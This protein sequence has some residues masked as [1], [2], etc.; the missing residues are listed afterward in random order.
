MVAAEVRNPVQ[1]SATAAR[2]IKGLIGSSVEKVG[3]GARL[4]ERLEALM[5]DIVVGV[6]RG[7]QKRLLRSAQPAAGKLRH[8][9]NQLGHL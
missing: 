7:R 2:E 5:Q 6:R 4:V 9:L 3:E 8:R 1:R